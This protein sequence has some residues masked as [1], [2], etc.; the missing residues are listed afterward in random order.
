[1]K[2]MAVAAAAIS[3]ILAPGAQ[4]AGKQAATP[5]KVVNIYNWSNYIDPAVLADFTRETGIRV[6]NDARYDSYDSNEV[7]FSRVVAGNSGYDIVVP[8]NEFLARM[9]DGGA[10]A[11]LDKTKLPN[12][13]NLDPALTALMEKYDPGNQYGVI[14]LWGTTGIGLNRDKIRQ[15]MANPPVDSLAMI[16]DPAIVARF[17]DCGVAMLDAPSEIIPAVLRYLGENP[18]DKDVSALARAEA[19]LLKIRR[20]IRKFHSS[21]YIDDLANGNICLAM[22]WSGDVLQ[23]RMRAE[24]AGKGVVVQY[25]VPRQGAQMWFDSMAIPKDAPNPGNA[26]A[27]INFIQRPEV[28]ARITNKVRYPNAN[29]AADPFVAEEVK[30]DPDIYPTPMMQKN[31]YTITPNNQSEQRLFMQVWSRFKSAN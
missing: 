10:L 28:I 31:L 18:D 6:R 8:T 12:L 24:Q 7:A 26:L 3:L 4:A 19:Q 21:Q 1:M 22:G 27:F 16:F 14:Y 30:A 11:K 29:R 13:A 5:D 25:L 23:A 20:H 2:F 15:R 9:I 17:S